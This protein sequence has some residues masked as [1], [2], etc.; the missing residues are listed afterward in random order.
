MNENS[1][2]WVVKQLGDELTPEF[3]RLRVEEGLG[4]TAIMQRQ[5]HSLWGK[6]VRSCP[7]ATPFMCTALFMHANGK[8]R[9][10]M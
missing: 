6:G 2:T 7:L 1:D 8:C 9:M 3:R 4:W 5:M 10:M